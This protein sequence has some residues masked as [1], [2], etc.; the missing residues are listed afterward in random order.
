MGVHNIKMSCLFP[1]QSLKFV[2]AKIKREVCFSMLN[3]S[4]KAKIVFAVLWIPG[5]VKNVVYHMPY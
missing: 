5:C 1:K 3:I 4:V 2:H